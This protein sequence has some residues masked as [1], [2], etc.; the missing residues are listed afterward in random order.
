MTNKRSNFCNCQLAGSLARVDRFTTATRLTTSTYCSFDISHFS[1]SSQ[2]VDCFYDFIFMANFSSDILRK[3]ARFVAL[4][5]KSSLRR[6]CYTLRIF[7]A[8]LRRLGHMCIRLGHDTSSTRRLQEELRPAICSSGLP[9]IHTLSTDVNQPGDRPHSTLAAPVDIAS[10]QHPLYLTP[11]PHPNSRDD[12]SIGTVDDIPVSNASFDSGL[13]QIVL[14][15][16]TT[17]E[18]QFVFSGHAAALSERIIKLVPIIPTDIKRYDRNIKMKWTEPNC[19]VITPKDN[20]YVEEVQCGWRD[21]V[22]PEGP[23]VYYHHETRVF[24]DADMRLGKMDSKRLLGMAK[25][26]KDYAKSQS[27]VQARIG[28]GTELVLELNTEKGRTNIIKS[29]GYYFV[30]HVKRVIFWAHSYTCEP[31]GEIL[32]NVKA[33]KRLSH[34]KYSLESQYWYHCELYP[35]NRYLPRQ[36]F[37]E[38]R[39][40]IVHANAETITSDTSL[41]PFDGNELAKMLDLMDRIEGSIDK[42]HAYSVCVV[43]RFMRLFTKVKFT[44]FCGQPGVR[45]D[46]DRSIYYKEG[47]ERETLIFRLLNLILWYGPRKHYKRVQR[48][49]VDEI[50]NAPRWKDFINQLDNE[51]LGFTIYSTVM[52]A[53]DVSFLA[54]PGI[55]DSSLQISPAIA[56][57]M[58]SL[59]SVGSLVLA[60]LLVDQSKDYQTAEDGALYMSLMTNGIP[61]IENL[62]LMHSLPYALLVWAMVFF[63]LALSI[64]IFDTNDVVTLATMTPGWI[65]VLIFTLWPTIFTLWPTMNTA[66]GWLPNFARSLPRQPERVVQYLRGS[67]HPELDQILIGRNSDRVA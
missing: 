64:F 65:I 34:I 11:P 22:H 57:Y 40:I 16:N 37:E 7:Y 54:V 48:V 53:V 3:F 43:A 66:V 6:A 29:C 38:L 18:P 1:F 15:M 2:T 28:D 23:R 50:I 25:A 62:A 59:C 67:R 51:W 33:A 21:F 60:V 42:M 58:S 61:G 19:F 10:P 56:V 52:L 5:L 8:L 17:D 35:H 12:F 32:F 55:I 31:H 14:E 4:L 26:L 27:D 44:N 30:D 13:P 49:W 45:V 41:A 39:E 36:I 9:T 20:K 46:A 47:H 63:G 24:T